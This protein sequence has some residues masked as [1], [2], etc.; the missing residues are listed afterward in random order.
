MLATRQGLFRG[1]LSFIQHWLNNETPPDR[2]VRWSNNKVIY[3]GI[4]SFTLEGENGT[5]TYSPYGQGIFR[6]CYCA[7]GKKEPRLEGNS[8]TIDLTKQSPDG[9]KV[10]LTADTAEYTCSLPGGIEAGITIVDTDGTVT[11]RIASEKV[12]LDHHPVETTKEWLLVEKSLPRPGTVGV[13]GL[14]ENTPP[15]E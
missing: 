8:W 7:G 3:E 12:M 13:F 1:A 15:N 4:D 14:G 6:V 11:C 2:G 10:N 5:I 9:W